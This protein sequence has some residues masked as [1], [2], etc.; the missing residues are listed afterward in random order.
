MSDDL[1]GSTWIA[2]SINPPYASHFY[3]NPTD[4]T[5]SEILLV[6]SE[7]SKMAESPAWGDA[8]AGD[9]VTCFM[10]DA[11]YGQYVITE[12]SRSATTWNIHGY[13][14]EGHG[15]VYGGMRCDIN[16]ETSDYVPDNPPT[17][18]DPD[19]FAAADHEH[20]E[21]AGTG[22]EHDLPEHAHTEYAENAHGHS[23]YADDSHLHSE[24]AD[25]SHL[26]SEY[27]TADHTHSNGSAQP[28]STGVLVTGTQ[29]AQALGYPQTNDELDA[30]A[31]AACLTLEPLLPTPTPV[32]AATQQAGLVIAVDI[33]QARTAAAGQPIGLDFQPGPYQMGRSL[34]TRVSGLIAPY[35]A[36]GTLAV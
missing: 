33:W 28:S 4:F 2:D 18:L 5:K 7:T 32:N 15:E 30:A 3:A 25:E 1:G 29:L 34:T 9:I 8:K 20:D 27:A 31:A 26:H 16:I 21:Y 35:R 23:E 6:I 12:I 13:L 36:V 10:T 17:P 14:L 19:D 11:N 22:H 24:Y